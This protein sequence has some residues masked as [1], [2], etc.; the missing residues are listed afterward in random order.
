[1]IYGYCNRKEV[2]KEAHTIYIWSF[3]YA[4]HLRFFIAK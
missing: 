3:Y 1:M 4:V 2:E